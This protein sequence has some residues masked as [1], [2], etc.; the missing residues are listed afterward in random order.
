MLFRMNRFG[1]MMTFPT[2]ETCTKLYIPLE[3]GTR[4]HVRRTILPE[5]CSL[6]A[7][8]DVG[9]GVPA[10]FTGKLQSRWCND[11]RPLSKGKMRCVDCLSV[12]AATREGGTLLSSVAE[13]GVEAVDPWPSREALAGSKAPW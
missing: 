5:S 4:A 7:N 13:S 6:N 10:S 1:R 2:G 11:V 9:L 12:S 3:A 8:G